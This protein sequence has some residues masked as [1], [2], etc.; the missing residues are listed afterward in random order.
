MIFVLHQQ[1]A[2]IR[3]PFDIDA[4]PFEGLFIKN[5]KSR[6]YDCDF[7][8]EGMLF[9]WEGYVKK[10]HVEKA[11][12][13]FVNVK[14]GKKWDER[15]SDLTDVVVIIRRYAE[16]KEKNRTGPSSFVESNISIMYLNELDESYIQLSSKSE[17]SL[18]HS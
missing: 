8:A 12:S 10:H 1:P 14:K 16:R 13:D 17:Y 7:G 11:V 4:H 2:N 18:K 9:Y 3:H 15:V 5:D 6:F